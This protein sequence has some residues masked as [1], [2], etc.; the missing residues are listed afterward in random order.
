M[1][2]SHP[3]IPD[4]IMTHL[5]VLVKLGAP[6]LLDAVSRP[7]D[8]LHPRRPLECHG[9]VEGWLGGARH[10]GPHLDIV[11]EGDVIC[12]VPVEAVVTLG[13]GDRVQQQVDGGHHLEHEEDQQG[14][15]LLK[16]ILTSSPSCLAAQFLIAKLPLM[17]SF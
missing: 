4:P 8:L 13:E 3:P 15:E 6:G 14:A 2:L 12:R 1:R 10:Q 7:E 17:K 11:N 9:G 16:L 5:E